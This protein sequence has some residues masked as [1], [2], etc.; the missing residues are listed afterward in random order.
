ME[1]LWF[2]PYLPFFI[3]SLPIQLF[4]L[5]SK[6]SR[7]LFFLFSLPS[8]CPATHCDSVESTIL[9]ILMFKERI[10]LGLG[11]GPT[12]SSVLHTLTCVRHSRG[13]NLRSSRSRQTPKSQTHR[14]TDEYS[15]NWCF[16]TGSKG[17]LYYLATTVFLFYATTKNLP[18]Q[19]L[20][21]FSR[22]S[23]MYE[24]S[25][26]CSKFAL[27]PCFHYRLTLEFKFAFE[28]G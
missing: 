5:R 24:V 11:A 9:E 27:P 22:L 20:R 25:L 7:F 18:P 1:L 26:P 3:I 10:A 6:F 13:Q 15:T 12:V 4:S 19:K 28:V 14:N 2:P 23:I 16:S 8:T 21:N 17:Y